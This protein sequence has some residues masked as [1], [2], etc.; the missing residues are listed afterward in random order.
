MNDDL[1]CASFAKSL[2]RVR[3]GLFAQTGRAALSAIVSEINQIRLGVS[4]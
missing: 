3:Q 4:S 1:H 2:E